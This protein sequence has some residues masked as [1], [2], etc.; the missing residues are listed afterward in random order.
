MKN[1]KLKNLENKNINTVIILKKKY[2]IVITIIFYFEF[3]KM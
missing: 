2:Q 1:L 3:D